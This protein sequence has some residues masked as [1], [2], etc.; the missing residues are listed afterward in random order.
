[1]RMSLSSKCLFLHA[2]NLRLLQS[3]I[4]GVLRMNQTSTTFLGFYTHVVYQRKIK[5]YCIRLWQ[6]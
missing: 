6:H 5:S 4:A 3:E 1:M 2:K